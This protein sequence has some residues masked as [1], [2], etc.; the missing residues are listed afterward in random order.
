MCLKD[1]RCEN[2]V[3]DV[4]EQDENKE[5]RKKKGKIHRDTKM[6]M[7]KDIKTKQIRHQHTENDNSDRKN[8]EEVD[9]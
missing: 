6:M 9:K 7:T 4:Y 5:E 3:D 8:I 1:T 2:G